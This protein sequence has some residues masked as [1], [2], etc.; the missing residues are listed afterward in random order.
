MTVL[1]TVRRQLQDAAE[2]VS[3][4]SQRRRLRPGTVV[5]ASTIVASLAVAVLA[6]ALL[7][8]SRTAPNQP[9]GQDRPHGFGPTAAST[10]GV[11]KLLTG[12]GIGS[13]TF[14]QAPGTVAVALERLLGPTTSAGAGGGGRTGLVGSICGL[15]QE[16]VWAGLAAKSRRPL[17]E[18]GQSV[19]FTSGLY[20]YFKRSRFVGY[21]Y[22]QYT[23]LKR[24]V[25]HGAAAGPRLATSRGLGLSDTLARGR[26]LYGS[27]FVNFSG[28]QGTPPNPR[29]DRTTAWRARTAT[30]RIYGFV[31]KTAQQRRISSQSTI[32]SIAAGATP[33]T[34]CKSP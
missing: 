22:Y 9:A 5:V 19:V 34:P 31:A 6:V 4:G 1:P 24:D 14:G 20:V 10:R 28:L 13:V 29:L 2:Q 30:G 16:I 11:E 33:N 17:I 18:G 26:R 15:N 32:A 3:H 25:R 21:S 12:D 23:S 8:H 27:A 7:G